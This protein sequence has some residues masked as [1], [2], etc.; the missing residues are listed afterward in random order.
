L[1]SSVRSYVFNEAGVKNLAIKSVFIE[2]YLLPIAK[3]IFKKLL[4]FGVLTSI[5]YLSVVDHNI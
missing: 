5:L 1:P 2:S 4:Y 3:I